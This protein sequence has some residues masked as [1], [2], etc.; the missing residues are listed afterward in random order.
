MARTTD[1]IAKFQKCGDQSQ[2]RIPFA[3]QLS[4]RFISPPGVPEGVAA[5]GVPSTEATFPWRYGVLG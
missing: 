3:S 2:P 4:I 1:L 5:S